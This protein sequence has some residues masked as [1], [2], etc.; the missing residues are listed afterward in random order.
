MQSQI[1]NYPDV[2]FIEGQ[3]LEQA[4][5]DGEAIW[6]AKWKECTGEDIQ[7]H[8]TDEEKILIDTV[9]YMFY[10]VC[11]N[12][13]NAGKMNLLKYSM[14]NFLDNLG[15]RCGVIRIAA[16]PAQTTVKFTLTEAQAEDY[17]IPEGTRVSASSMDDIYFET[18]EDVVIQAGETETDIICVCTTDGDDGNDIG[19]GVIDELIDALPYIDTVSNITK[20]DGG[21]DTEDD[22]A[23]AERIFY[24]PSTYST[25]GTEDSYIFHAKSASQLVGDVRVFSPQPCYVTIVITSR[26]TGV[27]TQELINIV[28]NYL[29]ERTR[30]V[31]SDRFTVTGP[32]TVQFDVTMTYYISY[33]N[34]KYEE[35]LKQR[36]EE[37]VA[38]YISWQTTKIG[39]NITPTKLI[40]LAME[41][42]ASRVE[43]SYPEWAD[44]DEDE[45]AVLDSISI[46]Y[47]GLEND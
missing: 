36:I 27:P 23:L 11:M 41:A 35:A 29:N 42:G 2:D 14:N 37:S 17:T 10:C 4:I 1:Q 38:E 5:A 32:D 20:S 12:I 22:D 3:T 39:R 24:A 45:I 31:L 44:V 34:Q 16:S 33:D 13:D 7:L 21:A 15:A 18:Q 26:R 28:T 46:T 30:K 8:K 43:L 47:G 40:Q 19:V 6:I 9:A 25:A